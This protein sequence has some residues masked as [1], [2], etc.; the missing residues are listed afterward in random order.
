MHS[1]CKQE[2]I[3]LG[4]GHALH[5]L[6]LGPALEQRVVLEDGAQLSFYIQAGMVSVGWCYVFSSG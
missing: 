2:A 4:Y 5:S 6:T 3:L 1:W